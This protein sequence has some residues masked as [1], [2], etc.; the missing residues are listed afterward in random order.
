M[1]EGNSADSAPLS[2]TVGRTD[3]GRRYEEVREIEKWLLMRDDAAALA[4]MKKYLP[5]HRASPK[6][7]KGVG[8]R[9]ATFAP[10]SAL[11]VV[12]ARSMNEIIDALENGDSSRAL[13]LMKRCHL[14]EEPYESNSKERLQ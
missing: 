6:E 7:L 5:G 4:L 13:R 2:R 14:P 10:L 3:P 12:L 11:A 9:K 1:P 8:W